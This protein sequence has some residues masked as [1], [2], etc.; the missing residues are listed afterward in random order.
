[1]TTT[2]GQSRRSGNYRS[3]RDIGRHAD[4]SSSSCFL[5][6]RARDNRVITTQSGRLYMAVKKKE[7]CS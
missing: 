3:G 4:V 7:E 5:A 2:H 1:M 6:E